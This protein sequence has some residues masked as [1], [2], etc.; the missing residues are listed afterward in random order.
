MTLND[1]RSFHSGIEHLFGAEA[2]R[3][4]GRIRIGDRVIR[5]EVFPIG[6]DVSTVEK[7]R[8]ID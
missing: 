4:D 8:R 1:L 3:P 5:A 7:P 6:V 2:L